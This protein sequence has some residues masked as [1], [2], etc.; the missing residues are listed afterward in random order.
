M[1]FFYKQ[2]GAAYVVSDADRA[3][4]MADI[5]ASRPV[6]TAGRTLYVM[7]DEP[8]NAVDAATPRPATVIRDGSHPS[9]R[10]YWQVR[11]HHRTHHR[12][13]E[14]GGGLCATKMVRYMDWDA[15]TRSWKLQPMVNH[16]TPEQEKVLDRY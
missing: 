13:R 15:A 1:N 14:L 9:H 2:A 16:A 4:I 3:S 10:W 6:D 5:M 11:E 8:Q 12:C 7:Y